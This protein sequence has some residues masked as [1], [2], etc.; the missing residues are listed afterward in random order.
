[1]KL[2]I[3][4]G[5]I[6]MAFQSFT[7]T[8]ITLAPEAE[9]APGAIRA[10]GCRIRYL[11]FNVTRAPFNNVA[12]R[13]AVAYLMPRQA[14][15]S[16]GVSGLRQ[17]ALLDAAG[18]VCPATSTR[19]RTSTGAGRTSR[20]QGESS[21]RQASRRRCRSRLWYTPTHYGD[22]SADEYAEIK[23]GTREARRSSRVTLKSSEWA[24]YS[25][26]L[27]RQYNA[28]QLGW[29]PD[30]VDI[31]NYVV[32]FYRSDTFLANGYKNAR[33]ESLIRTALATRNESAAIR[34]LSPDPDARRAGRLDHS[35]LAGQ[36]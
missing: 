30:Y 31:E 8:E 23:R 22:A 9:R 12:V 18:G 6:D 15:A 4:R 26:V 33:I 36:A 21:S 20:Q 13:R 3:Q 1:M 28:F 16:Q 5:E 32:P 2:A 34:H 24:Q 25:D 11:M 29:F 17:A 7:P 27:G 10:S 14:I 19:S 35:V